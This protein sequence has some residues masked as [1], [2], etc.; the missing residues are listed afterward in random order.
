M[1]EDA[2]FEP[3]ARGVMDYPEHERT[4]GRFLGLVKYGTIVVVA[5]LVFM[6]MY[7][8]AAAGVITSFL[9]ALVFGGVASF[10]MATGDQ[11]SMK[12]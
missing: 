9:S 12:H 10:L 4:Y 6:L 8:I 1:A 3:G 7:F 5:I 11:K 2:G